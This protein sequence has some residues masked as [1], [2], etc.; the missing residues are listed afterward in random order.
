MCVMDAT[1]RV[2]V[3]K[4][5]GSPVQ[6]YEVTPDRW[7]LFGREDGAEWVSEL[8]DT[9]AGNL[10]LREFPDLLDRRF[11]HVVLP[12]EA[13]ARDEAEPS[14]LTSS[15]SLVLLHGEAG[16][17]LIN[18]SDRTTVD[19]RS[20]GKQRVQLR[21]R[22]DRRLLQERRLA[23]WVPSNLGGPHRVEVELLPPAVPAAY[24]SGR[25]T[26]LVTHSLTSANKRALC[27]FFEQF[28]RWD[29]PVREPRIGVYGHERVRALQAAGRS[30][31]YGSAL[32]D[33]FKSVAERHEQRDLWLLPVTAE[34]SAH[35]WTL[36]S[37]IDSG[38]LTHEDVES[39][40]SEFDEA[41]MAWR[42]LVAEQV[43]RYEHGLAE[44]L[45]ASAWWLSANPRTRG[46]LL[47][48]VGTLVA[49]AL[50][51]RHVVK[52]AP[53][54][55]LSSLEG[56]KVADLHSTLASDGRVT[57]PVEDVLDAAEL[58]VVGELVLRVA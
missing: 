44:D 26:G 19:V 10:L 55:F 17:W 35:L 56:I 33:I 9:S 38:E 12:D 16:W 54:A 32:R 31:P 42:H 58:D 1:L 24:G 46:K 15:R 25:G 27:F 4:A 51:K 43:S 50:E 6:E 21:P 7:L 3:V 28:M 18:P 49:F 53:E 8:V 36:E 41:E 40:L 11:T 2:R 5:D 29:P 48:R 20:W 37:A 13:L 45:E 22:G 57:L 34:A 39:V 23:F 14:Y 52:A 47:D 30:A